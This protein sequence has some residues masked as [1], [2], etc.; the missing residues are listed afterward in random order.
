MHQFITG[1]WYRALY[2]VS[3]INF[4]RVATL[5][6]NLLDLS[7]EPE[8]AI[9]FYIFCKYLLTVQEARGILYLSTSYE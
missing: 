2:I 5:R 6:R 9:A 8:N 3:G 7:N 4:N 1:C